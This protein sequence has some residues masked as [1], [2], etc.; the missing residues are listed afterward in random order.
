MAPEG[1]GD[2]APEGCEKTVFP[3]DDAD[4][5]LVVDGVED[6]LGY[7]LW[8][9]QHGVVEV[10][11]KEG[12]VYEAWT[13]IRELDVQS[14]GVG[15]LFQRLQVDILHGFGGRVAWG[16]AEAFGA[17]NRGDGCDVSA[18][19][20]GKVAIGFTNH[21]GEAQTVGIHRS[22]F[23]IFLK[24]TVLFANARGVE[25]EVHASQT[26]DERLEASGGVV[27]CDVNLFHC[28]SVELLKFVDSSGCH[29]DGPAFLHEKFGNFSSDA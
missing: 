26:T 16:R 1:A 6:F 14:S 29:T 24:L 2:A 4:V 25:E 18:A 3:V 12:C 17:S 28:C 13:D 27:F 21:S 20:V 15:L 10:A 7:G 11:M 8:L 5:L 22:E 9:E 23:D 19:F